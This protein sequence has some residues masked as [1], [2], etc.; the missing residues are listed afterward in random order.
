MKPMA[1][2]MI[3][4]GVTAVMVHPSNLDCQVAVY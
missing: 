1:I 2:F 3:G 4:S